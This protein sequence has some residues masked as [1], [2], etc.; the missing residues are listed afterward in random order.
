MGELV[1]NPEELISGREHKFGKVKLNDNGLYL[2]MTVYGKVQDV[3]KCEPIAIG[4][5]IYNIDTKEAYIRLIYKYQGSYNT[6]DV[7]ME[8]LKSSKIADLLRYGVDIPPEDE[9]FIARHLMEQLKLVGCEYVY[10]NVGWHYDSNGNL[11]FRLNELIT[12]NQNVKATNNLE[13]PTFNLSCSGTLKAW[14]DMF[15]SEIKGNTPLEAIMCIGF[16]APIV[17]YLY[18]KD[19]HTDTLIFH[20]AGKSTTGKTTGSKLAISPF[21]VPDTKGKGLFR[22]WNGTT[23]A[24]INSLG[25]NFGIPLVFDEFSMVRNKDMSREVY[26]MTAGEE[27][28]RLTDTITQRSRPKWATTIISTG[29]Q[30]I[31]ERANNNGGL[32]V[33][34]FTFEGVEWTKSAKNAD[35]IKAVISENYGFAGVEYMKYIFNKGFSIIDDKWEY[36]KNKCLEVIPDNPFKSRVADKFATIM[37]GGDIANEALGLDID[38]ESVLKFLADNEIESIEDRD[39]GEKAFTD[40]IQLIR[41]NITKFKFKDSA[42]TPGNCWGKINSEV[43]FYK[44]AVLKNVLEKQLRYLNYEDVRVVIKEWKEKGYLITEVGKNTNRATVSSQGKRDTVYI[45][46]IPILELREYVESSHVNQVG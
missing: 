32:R 21:G 16:S 18:R 35:N 9:K 34:A 37:T 36:W 46:K 40:I 28:A 13:N 2:P 41:Q 17:G 15:H 24:I 31:F 39:V 1:I 26:T 7:T 19:K 30:S 29:E 5:N 27:K 11:E 45:L 3:K 44:V 42:Y 33:R 8:M 22:T 4:K 25:G 14:T 20:M 10:N 38:L 6:I 12:N 23:N 43:T